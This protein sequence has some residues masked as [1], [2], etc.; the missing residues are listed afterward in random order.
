MHAELTDRPLDA[1]ALMRRVADPS[2]GGTVLF[3]GTVR[4]QNDGR[5]VT[6]LEYSAYLPMARRELE[7]ILVE[8]QSQWPG[9]EVACAHRIGALSLGDAA[10]VVAAAHPHRGA[11]FEACR[12][13][14]ESLKQRVPIWKREHYADGS[15]D[16]V[17]VRP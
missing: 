16:W 3:I 5:R 6:A 17:E 1:A 11:A 13:V 12:F 8:A 9:A 7:L 15:A 4:D 14:I 10:V 2:R